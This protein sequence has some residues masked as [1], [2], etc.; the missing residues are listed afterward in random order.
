MGSDS[1]HVISSNFTKRLKSL[2]GAL[3]ILDSETVAILSCMFE[4][5]SN[6]GTGGKGY[7]ALHYI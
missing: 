4:G 3:I 5:N 6:Y 2:S 7:E 1:V